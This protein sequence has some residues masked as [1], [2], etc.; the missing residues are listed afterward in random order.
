MNGGIIEFAKSVAKSV[1]KSVSKCGTEQSWNQI[2]FLKYTY[3]KL[4]N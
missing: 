2:H 1:V 4:F 3:I